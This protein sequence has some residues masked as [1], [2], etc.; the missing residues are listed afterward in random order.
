MSKVWIYKKVWNI[1][2]YSNMPPTQL[3]TVMVM[4][5][6]LILKTKQKSSALLPFYQFHWT[7]WWARYK[8][9]DDQQWS[10]PLTSWWV[11]QEVILHRLFIPVKGNAYITTAT[12][13]VATLRDHADGPAWKCGC[14]FTPLHESNWLCRDIQRQHLCACIVLVLNISNIEGCIRR[15]GSRGLGSNHRPFSPTKDEL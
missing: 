6:K 10:S 11:H 8:W 1:L 13:S 14:D 15:V 4:K 5:M 12:E 3:S 9:G 7:V 2:K